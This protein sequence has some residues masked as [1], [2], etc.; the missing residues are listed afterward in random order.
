MEI[1]NWKEFLFPYEQTVK[2]LVVK[3]QSLRDEYKMLEMYSPIEAVSGRVK[4]TTSIIE[5]ARRKNIPNEKIEELIEDI[6]GIRIIC[7]FE[8]DIEKVKA[9]IKERQD[10]I[11]VEEKDYITNKKTSGYRSYH[12]VIRYPVNTALGPKN[13]LAEIQLRTLSMN[14]WATAEHS[15][16]YKYSGNIPQELQER[17]KNCAEAAYNLDKE[18]STI[19][20]EIMYAKR[21][22]EIKNS[23]IA[24]IIDNIQRMYFVN[25]SSEMD[26]INN[27]FSRLW[28]EGN[29]EKLQRFNE[30]LK[31]TWD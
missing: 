21:K 31:K 24:E 26:K 1:A 23:I 29:L 2:E 3:F 5:K 20:T 7:K 9:L 22:N 25:I 16:K 27:E 6:A 17:L 15:L 13:I 8:E 28:Q 30:M 11:I 12:I 10:M 18:M 4:R 14:F 19:R